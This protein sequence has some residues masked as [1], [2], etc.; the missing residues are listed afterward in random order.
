MSASAKVLELMREAPLDEHFDGRVPTLVAVVAELEQ[1][2]A[3]SFDALPPGSTSVSIALPG[4][5]GRAIRTTNGDPVVAA[6]TCLRD[7]L[8]TVHDYARQGVESL[9]AFLDEA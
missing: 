7:A 8:A 5:I 2:G 9:E 4:W 3:V 6:L 1:F